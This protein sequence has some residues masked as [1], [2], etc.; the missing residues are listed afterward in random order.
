MRNK[1]TTPVR[2]IRAKCLECAGGRP[3]LV[4]NCE[5]PE[6][7]LFVF[8]MGRNPQR[9]GI[10]GPKK[11]SG[12][13]VDNKQGLQDPTGNLSAGFSNDQPSHDEIALAA[14]PVSSGPVCGTYRDL[15]VK[16]RHVPGA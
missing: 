5:S 11:I 13:P 7:A 4:R 10:G 1:P 16:V 9:R 8:R 3:S 15:I 6:C 14:H 12:T 2:S